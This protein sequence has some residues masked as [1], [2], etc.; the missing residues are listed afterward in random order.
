MIA[1]NYFEDA[2]SF[3]DK[4][5]LISKCH[6]Y[7]GIKLFLLLS[8]CTKAFACLKYIYFFNSGVNNSVQNF[9]NENILP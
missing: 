6:Q 4:I 8:T 1:F 9:N 7:I 5:N 2:G 3:L